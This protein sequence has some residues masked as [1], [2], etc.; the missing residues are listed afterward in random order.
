MLMI[1]RNFG[2][3]RG[4]IR[5]GLSYGE[6]ALGAA[7]LRQPVAADV[8]RLV[9]VCHGNI[10][11]SAYADV[12]ARDLG[13]NVASFGLSTDSGKGAHPPVIAEAARRGVDMS[14]H[15]T[16]RIED[17]DPDPGDL[18]LAMETRHLRKLATNG[19]VG[20]IPRVLLGRWSR[21]PFPHLHDP[22]ALSAEYLPVC[23]DRIEAA[24]RRLLQAFPNARAGI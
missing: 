20:T 1:E 2:T 7:P 14:A 22:Y 8:T 9:F 10:C 11:R 6:I 15:R 5:L 21:P 12:V 13:M 3:F 4:L 18:L 23:L 17:F 24:T 19:I 16:T